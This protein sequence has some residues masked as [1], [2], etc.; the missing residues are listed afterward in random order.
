LGFE[1]GRS[2]TRLAVRSG[3]T[4]LQTSREGV[5]L[6]ALEPLANGFFGDGKRGGRTT[7]R[8][9]GRLVEVDQLGSHPGS[10]FGISV[11]SVRE[12]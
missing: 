2:F 3:G 7:E 11:H 6:R 1:E 8:V 5:S 4:V 10:E 9:A 12:G